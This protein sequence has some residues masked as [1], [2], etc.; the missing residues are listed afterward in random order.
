MCAAVFGGLPSAVPP[1]VP[2]VSC[3][4]TRSRLGGLGGVVHCSFQGMRCGGISIVFVWIVSIEMLYIGDLGSYWRERWAINHFP[5][6]WGT[7]LLGTQNF[8]YQGIRV[9]PTIPQ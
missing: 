7:A 1:K 8:F 5:L 6:G 3:S 4:K 9:E 2:P